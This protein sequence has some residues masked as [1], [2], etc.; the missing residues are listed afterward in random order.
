MAGWR[1]ALLVLVGVA[2]AATA[3]DG[4]PTK[5]KTTAVLRKLRQ[6]QLDI[7]K[8]MDRLKER[9]GSITFGPSYSIERSYI[10]SRR[11]LDLE[12]E[13]AGTTDDRRAALKGHYQ[14][15]KRLREGMAPL[16]RN[17]TITETDYLATRFY[18][19]QAEYWVKQESDK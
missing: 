2:L 7:I 17:N 9:A 19:L 1:G 13:A 5:A 10:W 8:E 12:R 15:M 6:D 4:P 14:R 3:A 18:Q 16:F 11:Q